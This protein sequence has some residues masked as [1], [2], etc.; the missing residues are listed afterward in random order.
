MKKWSVESLESIQL[1]KNIIERFSVSITSVTLSGAIFDSDSTE[2]TLV[3][4]ED[5]DCERKVI[6]YDTVNNETAFTFKSGG[7]D[8]DIIVEIKKN[9]VIYLDKVYST[10]GYIGGLVDAVIMYI[11]GSYHVEPDTIVFIK[12]EGNNKDIVEVIHTVDNKIIGKTK[13]DETIELSRED[14]VDIGILE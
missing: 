11:D 1:M 7:D 9:M 3:D 10:Q 14:F 2:F 8:F 4:T 6:V 12:D 13:T 5:V